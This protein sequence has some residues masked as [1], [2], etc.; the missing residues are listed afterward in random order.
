MR[1]RITT[2]I[3]VLTAFFATCLT[4]VGLMYD[5]IYRNPFGHEPILWIPIVTVLLMLFVSVPI[6]ILDIVMKIKKKTYVNVENTKD[7]N[8]RLFYYKKS[9]SIKDDTELNIDIKNRGE[10]S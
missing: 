10:N 3:S 1:R 5:K 8:D 9:Q 4:L 6:V 2:Y 7:Q